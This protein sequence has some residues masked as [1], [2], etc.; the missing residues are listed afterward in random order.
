MRVLQPGLLFLTLGS[1]AAAQGASGAPVPATALA[2]ASAPAASSAPASAKAPV[3]RLVT[4]EGLTEPFAVALGPGGSLFIADAAAN[5]VI[6]VDAHGQHSVLAGTGEKGLSGDDG[7]AAEARLSAPHHILMGPDG[8]L[9]VADTGNQCVRRIDLAKKTIARVAGT[10]EKGFAGDGGPARDATFGGIYALAFHRGR[11]YLCD[12]GSRRIRAV[13]MAS[14]TV[15]TVAGNGEKGVPKD[16]EDARTQ[17]LFDP[18][19][20]AVDDGGNVYILERDGHA[21]RRVDP[22]GRIRTVAGTGVAGF[23][24]D[25]GPAREAELRGPKH[26]SMDGADVLISDTENHVIRRYSPADGKVNRVAG[27]GTK[28]ESGLDGP[29]DQCALDRPHGAQVDPATGA[30]Y[31]SDSFNH[32]VLRI[33]PR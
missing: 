33:D 7:P 23:S 1:A 8:F 15:T 6:A 19:A 31:I 16:D 29:P 12:L 17:P 28:G 27:T 4:A 18:R 26:I 22:A 10:G 20:V 14:G 24:G 11:L 9:Y 21:L 13:D 3:I 25:G 32:R 30:L 2:P 5:R